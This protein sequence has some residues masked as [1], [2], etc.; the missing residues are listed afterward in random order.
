M[1]SELQ[2]SDCSD[3]INYSGEKVIQP[4]DRAYRFD[5]VFVFSGYALQGRTRADAETN[6]RCVNRTYLCP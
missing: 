3:G 4:I 1:G 5:I 2:K 6:P